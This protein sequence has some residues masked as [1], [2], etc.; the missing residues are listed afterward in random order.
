MKNKIISLLLIMTL[1]VIA[2]SLTGCLSK[3]SI[4]GETF[5]QM[6]KAEGY[7]V[8]DITSQYDSDLAKS[9]LLAVDPSESFQIEYFETVNE[10]DAISSYQ[11]NLSTMEAAKGSPYAGTSMSGMNYNKSTMVT[12]GEFYV[13]SRIDNTFIFVH[14][15]E[16]NKSAVESM[17]DKL[18]Y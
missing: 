1:I 12:N 2:I 16:T 8:V 13:V 14:T 15:S 18:G 5:S 3:T 10:S 17:L 6:A 11:G 9:V 7:R 4:T